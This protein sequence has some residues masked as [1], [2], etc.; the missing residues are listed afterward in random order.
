VNVTAGTGCAWTAS[1]NAPWLTITSG[2]TGTGNGP[3]GFSAAANA[4]GSRT[5]TLT[6]AGQTFTVTQA[7]S[8]G[9]LNRLP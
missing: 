5:G 4:G 9:P 1:S 2:A 3:V 6:I 7:A 8:I